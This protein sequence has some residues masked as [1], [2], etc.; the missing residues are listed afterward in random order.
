[1]SEQ[2]EKKLPEGWVET[3]LDTILEKIANGSNIKQNSSFSE[4][5]YPISRIETIWNETFDFS[6]V[7]Y[8]APNEEEI[9][10]YSL[11]KG[12]ILFSHINSDKHLGK[13]ALFDSKL[14]LIHGI[15]LL[16]IRYSKNYNNRL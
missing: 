10:K 12:D 9:E 16:L 11:K 2:I 7:K 1:M 6:R 8:C 3:N 4:G 5:L 15:N 13:T 14:S